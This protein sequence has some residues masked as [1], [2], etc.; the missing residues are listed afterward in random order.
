MKLFLLNT[1]INIYSEKKKT[2]SGET[3]DKNDKR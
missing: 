1:S 2:S 3:F